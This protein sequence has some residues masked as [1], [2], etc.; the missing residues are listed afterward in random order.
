MVVVV[1]GHRVAAVREDLVGVLSECDPA[2]RPAAFGGGE[3]GR[4]SH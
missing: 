4:R 2:A 1:K 3:R